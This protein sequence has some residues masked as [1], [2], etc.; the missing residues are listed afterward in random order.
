MAYTPIP[1]GSSA[2]TLTT[3]TGLTDKEIVFGAA[4]GTGDSSAD[5]KY[6]DTTND[7]TVSASESGGT[8][9]ITLSN[10]SDTANS[11]AREIISTAG[12][13]ADDPALQF[14]VA[15]A[16]SY[17]LGVDNS[18]A[19]DPLVLSV[20]TALGTTDALSVNSSGQVGIGG[21]PLAISALSVQ[22]TGALQAEVTSTTSTLT[23]QLNI[24]TGSGRLLR[25][26]CN[27][28]SAGGNTTYGEPRASLAEISTT[29]IVKLAF[30]T[31][32]NFLQ[33]IMD[34]G[35]PGIAVVPTG[36]ERAWPGGT[37]KTIQSDTG[38]VTTGEDTL[39]TY[40]LPASML[41]ADGMGIEV[42]TIVTYAANAESKQ[43]KLHF[44][45][46]VIADT[47]ATIQN[48][49][50]IIIK[51]L[52]TR[53]GAATQRAMAQIVG[54]P[55]LIGAS[56]TY[57]TPAETLSGTIVIKVTGESVST[58]SIINRVTRIRWAAALN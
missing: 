10:T 50:A 58:D 28:I 49:G 53:T 4:D 44:G 27:S 25:L 16:Q 24:G 18:V 13:S 57:T 31:G 29:S 43:V 38:N 41:S 2:A 55:A 1:A 14:T 19:G 6:D 12:T 15:G 22:G 26:V 36:I 8:V 7:L 21:A 35:K 34:N 40:T 23:S 33:A 5:L 47:T 3:L 32:Q 48:G 46:T 42:E 52:I 17:T 56:S 45:G 54:P 11:A 20:G 9:G 30:L 39:H 51:A 37:I